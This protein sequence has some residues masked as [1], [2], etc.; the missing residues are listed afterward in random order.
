MPTGRQGGHQSFNGAHL[1]RVRTFV[2]SQFDPLL[3]T[4]LRPYVPTRPPN[5]IGHAAALDNHPVIIPS[6]YATMIPPLTC[7]PSR[8][9][10]LTMG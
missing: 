8:D 4:R 2:E 10:T 9:T 5:K 7:P 6:L 1:P 3:A